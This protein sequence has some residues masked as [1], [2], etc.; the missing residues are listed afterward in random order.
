MNQGRTTHRRRRSDYFECPLDQG[1]RSIQIFDRHCSHR[2]AVVKVEYSTKPPA[3]VYRTIIRS[4]SL[5]SIDQS[6]TEPLVVSFPVARVDT[7]IA[8][9]LNREKC[10]TH[11]ILGM[12]AGMH[13]RD[14]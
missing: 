3:P 1:T 7:L 5:V 8:I 11:G 9:S 2:F 6:V 10:G 4:N 12:P 14:L 13:L